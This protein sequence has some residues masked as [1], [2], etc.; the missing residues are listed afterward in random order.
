M[1]VPV[2][3]PGDPARA[4]R[5][6][7]GAEAMRHAVSFLVAA[8]VCFAA[9]AVVS[10]AQFDAAPGAVA[11]EGLT[12]AAAGAAAEDCDCVKQPPWHGSVQ[13]PACQSGPKCRG[14][15]VYQANPW[16]QLHWRQAGPCVT[17]PPCLPRFHALFAEGYLLSPVPPKL[18]RCHNCG[19]AIEGGF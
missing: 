10:A 2:S 15:N 9:P 16:A 14:S 4:I 6:R 11:A 7:E 5:A 3:A 12:G 17:L 13:G 19:A 1:A 18:P 8:A